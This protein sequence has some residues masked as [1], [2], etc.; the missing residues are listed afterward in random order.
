MSE[1][2]LSHDPIRSAFSDRP[3]LTEYVAEFVR[4]APE[5]A[6]SL[7]EAW[8]DERIEDLRKLAGQIRETGPDCGF[9]EIADAAAELE[10]AIDQ[11]AELQ[12]MRTAVEAL[13]DACRRATT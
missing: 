6:M 2:D 3:E 10:E 4:D 5:C 11:Q 8:R 7:C 9:E 13:V 1:R 12:R